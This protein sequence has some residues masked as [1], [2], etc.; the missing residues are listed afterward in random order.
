MSNTTIDH[1]SAKADAKAA[2]AY[3]K[4]T[5]PV[6]KKKRYWLLALVALIAIVIV[7]TQ[8]GGGG[9]DAPAPATDT[10]STSAKASKP[11]AVS[12]AHLIKQFEDNELKAD[13]KYKDKT[14]KVTGTVEK[15]DTETFDDS[16]YV[17]DLN[18]GGD[19]E[20]LSVTVYDIPNKDLGTINKGDKVTVTADFKDGGDLGVELNHG[21]LN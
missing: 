10:G 3:A 13:A 9:S 6:Y 11:V 1:K 8:A 21:V 12:A 16:D 14:L 15:V 20:I 5:R 18:G 4:A 7:A 2:K 19:F 17:L